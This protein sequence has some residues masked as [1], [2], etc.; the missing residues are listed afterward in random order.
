MSNNIKSLQKAILFSAITLLASC[1][2]L[3]NIPTGPE[4][5]KP[6]AISLK[7]TPDWINSIGQWNN[8]ENKKKDDYIWFEA[9]SPLENSLQGAKHDAYIRAQR[10]ASDRIGDQN[11]NLIGVSAKRASNNNSQ[12]V[13][14]IERKTKTQLRQ[15]SQGWLVGGE[16]YQ[17]YW[18]EYRPQKEIYSKV[19]SNER[20]LFRSW[21]LVRYSHNNW[22]CSRRNSLKML[23]MIANNMGGDLKFHKF[24]AE[25]FKSVLEDITNKNISLIPDSVCSGDN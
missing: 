12:I 15:M 11:W 25:T 22:E 20:S 19:P 3:P 21:V 18:I 17:Y 2:T 8:K 1:S 16:D 4:G 9:S 10:K 14:T 5:Y 23:P 24:N 7:K 6:V 13:D